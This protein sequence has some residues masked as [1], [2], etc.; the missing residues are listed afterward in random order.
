LKE[1]FENVT[2]NGIGC[3]SF[4]EK[5]QFCTKVLSFKLLLHLLQSHC[6]MGQ[7]SWVE[8]QFVMLLH[9]LQQE[10]IQVVRSNKKAQKRPTESIGTAAMDAWS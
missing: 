3:T 6:T 10:C 5:I 4:M 1:F 7:K 2:P 8:F 9:R